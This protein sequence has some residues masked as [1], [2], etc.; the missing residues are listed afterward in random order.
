[1]TGAFHADFRGMQRISG[2]ELRSRRLRAGLSRE[3]LAHEIGVPITAVTEWEEEVTPIACPHAV[4]QVLRQR[5]GDAG[6][7]LPHAS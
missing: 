7:R 1:M 3:R 5:E 6:E 4:E 2:Q